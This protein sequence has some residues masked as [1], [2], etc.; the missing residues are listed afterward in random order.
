MGVVSKEEIVQFDKRIRNQKF[1]I[2][3]NVSTEIQGDKC[4]LLSSLEGS[5]G[6][7]YMPIIILS[8]KKS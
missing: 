8:I 4:I 6:D 1:D 2:Y 5:D 3:D 7:S